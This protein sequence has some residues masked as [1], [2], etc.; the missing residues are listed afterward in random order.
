MPAKE[1]GLM[2][3]LKLYFKGKNHY[4][5]EWPRAA[6]G[7]ES[8]IAHMAKHCIEIIY[9]SRGRGRTVTTYGHRNT[10]KLICFTRRR[11]L[12]TR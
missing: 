2:W 4:K 6:V 7:G 11:L 9:V 10:A 3:K 12:I 5:K 8:E 1:L